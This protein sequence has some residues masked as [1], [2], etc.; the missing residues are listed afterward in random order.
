M[1]GGLEAAV[2]GHTGV[3]ADNVHAAHFRPRAFGKGLHGVELRHVGLDGEGLGPR[4][5]HP[6]RRLGHARFVD[7][8]H[9]DMGA[10]AR[11]GEAQ[12]APN[13]AGAPRDH[14]RLALEIFH[15][16]SCGWTR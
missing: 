12:R 13:S 5:L 10:L 7:V 2:H 4:L 16:I 14:R 11:E 15:A 8:C 3:V 9:H 1:G 6:R